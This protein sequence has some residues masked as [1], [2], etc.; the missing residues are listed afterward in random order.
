MMGS[1]SDFR[2]ICAGIHPDI[3]DGEGFIRALDGME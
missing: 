2:K 3:K 1:W